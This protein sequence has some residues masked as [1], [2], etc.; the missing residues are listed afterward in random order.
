MSGVLVPPMHKRTRK[1]F[2]V[3]VCRGDLA[4]SKSSASTEDAPYKLVISCSHG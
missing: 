2:L 3:Y 4:V 1:K